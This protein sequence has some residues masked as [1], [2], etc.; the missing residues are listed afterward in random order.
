LGEPCTSLAMER[1]GLHA[2]LSDLLPW[3]A[4]Q[5]GSPSWAA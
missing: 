5:G 4:R 3:R 1:Y 2:P